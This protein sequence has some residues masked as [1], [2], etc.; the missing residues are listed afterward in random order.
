VKWHCTKHAQ[1]PGEL[2]DISKY[3]NELRNSIKC[4][5]IVIRRANNDCPRMAILHTCY[6]IFTYI[7]DQILL[8]T[9]C[10]ISFCRVLKE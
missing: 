4:E 3:D 5:E 8:G 6:I 1:G 7:Y 9:Q 2:L 10:G